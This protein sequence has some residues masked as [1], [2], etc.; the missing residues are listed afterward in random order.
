[1]KTKAR[2][3]DRSFIKVILGW[4]SFSLFDTN[5]SKIN[6]TLQFLYKD[7]LVYIIRLQPCVEF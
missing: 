7:S 1:M 3:M 2:I 6:L 4:R 5:L